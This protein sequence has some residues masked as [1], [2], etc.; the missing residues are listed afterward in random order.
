MKKFLLFLMLCGAV[1]SC[2][3][4]NEDNTGISASAVPSGVTSSFNARYPSASGQIEWEK[5]DGNTYKVKFF[6][7]SQRWQAFFKADGTFLSESK[8]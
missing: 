7:G 3:K 5:E 2:H 1:V 8:I 6:Q 4:S